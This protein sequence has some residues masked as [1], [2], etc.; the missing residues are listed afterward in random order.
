MKMS[1]VD[2]DFNG[3]VMT[4]FSL[5]KRPCHIKSGGSFSQV[6]IRL[7]RMH[8]RQHINASNTLYMSNMDV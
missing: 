4:S 3:D 2:I 7:H 8:L 6:A 5:L 1:E